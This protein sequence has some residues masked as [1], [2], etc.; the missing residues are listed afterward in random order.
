MGVNV[1]PPVKVP[2][3]VLVQ[4]KPALFEAVAPAIVCVD[5]SQI[6][7]GK[8]AYAV[9]A[10]INVTST[11]SGGPIQPLASVS[12]TVKV[13]GPPAIIPQSIAI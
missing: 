6:L 1:F 3:P 10:N 7:A 13:C 8:P 2:V 12:I 5:P 11:L 9:A 4:L